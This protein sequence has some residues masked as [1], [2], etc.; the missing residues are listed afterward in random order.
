MTYFSGECKKYFASGKGNTSV[1]R[2]VKK[3]I[4]G[5]EVRTNKV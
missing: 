1:G 3:Q 2:Y 5:K 4:N